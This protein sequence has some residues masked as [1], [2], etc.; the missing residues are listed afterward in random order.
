MNK[1]RNNDHPFFVSESHFQVAFALAL[2]EEYK[3]LTVVPEYPF[4]KDKKHTFHIDL[5]VI[6]NKTKEMAAIEFKYVLNG[7]RIILSNNKEHNLRDHSAANLRREDYLEDI[8]RIE[9]IL[10]NDKDFKEGYAIILTN[11]ARIYEKGTNGKDKAFDISQSK[12]EISK[13]KHKFIDSKFD[14][15]PIILSNDYTI[16]WE[17]YGEIKDSKKFKYLSI[18]IE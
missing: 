18:K 9:Y 6:D 1:L 15:K 4:K 13:G 5:V 12:E 10:S 16:H 8:Q 14:H 3:N 7:G 2:K 17:D 11:M